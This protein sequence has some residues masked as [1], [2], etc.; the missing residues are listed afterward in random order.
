MHNL[1]PPLIH[2]NICPSSIVV[3]GDSTLLDSPSAK[4]HPPVSVRIFDLSFARTV[5]PTRQPIS[6]PFSL[7]SPPETLTTSPVYS[8]QGDVF[9]MCVVLWEIA[10][11]CLHS[12]RYWPYTDP[13]SPVNVVPGIEQMRPKIISG[14]RPNTDKLPSQLVSILKAGMYLSRHPL[15]ANRR[16]GSQA[17]LPT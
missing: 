15:I 2:A 4:T 17:I 6:P 11:R 3:T 14:E 12:R 7:H 8:L 13:K 1:N 16:L 10:M 5:Q 9:S